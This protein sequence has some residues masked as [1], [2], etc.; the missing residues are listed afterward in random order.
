VLTGAP[1]GFAAAQ[2]VNVIVS[3]AVDGPVTSPLLVSAVH[4]TLNPP[5]VSSVIPL[6]TALNGLETAD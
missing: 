3:A 4:V 1:R 2:P 6:L 5:I